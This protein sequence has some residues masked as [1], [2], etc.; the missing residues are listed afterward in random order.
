MLTSTY[1]PADCLNGK[2]PDEVF[3][4]KENKKVFC[5][6]CERLIKFISDCGESWDSIKFVKLDFEKKEPVIKVDY[7]GLYTFCRNYCDQIITE[8][9]VRAR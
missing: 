6:L 2:I 9:Y 5:S 7:N 3:V 4:T 1:T 8:A